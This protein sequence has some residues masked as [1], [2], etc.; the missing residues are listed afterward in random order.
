MQFNKK[1]RLKNGY[2]FLIKSSFNFSLQR[3]LIMLKISSGFLFLLL[4]LNSCQ[5]QQN[6]PSPLQL[7]GKTDTHLIGTDYQLQ[8]EAM[9]AL[10]QMTAAAAKA[11]INIKVVSAFRSYERQRAIWNRKYVA[12]REVGLSPEENRKKIITYSTLPGTSRHHWGTDIDI[13]DGGATVEGDVLLATHFHEG[14]PFEKLR[15]W[16]EA[17]A[18]EYGFYYAYPNNAERTGFNYEPWHYSYAPI[19][20]RYFE[21]FQNADL[22]EM[23]KDSLLEGQSDMTKIFLDDYRNTHINGVAPFLKN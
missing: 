19:A 4:L 22:Y 7:M 5:A 6:S 9:A 2:F 14:G 1:R 15:L 20:K 8:P 11:G 16:L 3:N 17:H 13:I 21:A 12:N 10:E 23:L 18:A